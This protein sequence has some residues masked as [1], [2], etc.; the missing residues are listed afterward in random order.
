MLNKQSNLLDSNPTK[1][2]I[3]YFKKQ[4]ESV[5]SNNTSFVELH[6]QLFEQYLDRINVDQEL[7]ALDSH[8]DNVAETLSVLQR[9]I[10]MKTIYMD[11]TYFDD[12]LKNLEEEFEAAPD[13]TYPDAM[14]RL[15]SKLEALQKSVSNSTIP[16]NHLVSNLVKYFSKRML[17]KS[18]TEMKS[19]TLNL[20]P[21]VC[22]PSKTSE[23][24]NSSLQR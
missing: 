4:I 17:K 22:K 15:D 13:I 19:D 16:S 24:V 5:Q 8:E 6:D 2:D 10:D 9:L 18:P 11:A 3:A 21:S 1:F 14:K 23:V 12:D 7:Q 20:T